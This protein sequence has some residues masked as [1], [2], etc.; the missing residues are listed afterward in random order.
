MNTLFKT[1]AAFAFSSTAAVAATPGMQLDNILVNGDEVRVE[2][3]SKVRSCG[4]LINEY[5]MKLG[6][7]PVCKN[8]VGVEIST[9]IDEIKVLPGQYVQMCK[10]NDPAECTD[11]VQVREAGDVNGDQVINVIDLMLVHRYIMGFD[12][13]AWPN[14]DIDLLAADLDDDGQINVIDILILVELLELD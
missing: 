10:A 3:S 1:L 11:F 6:R 9:T 7:K 12:T 8:G 2:Y 13:G 14:A 5:G 4:V